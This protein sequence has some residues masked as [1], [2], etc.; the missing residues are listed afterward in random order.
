MEYKIGSSSLNLKVSS[1]EG[2]DLDIKPAFEKE[3]GGRGYSAYEIALQQ[4]FVGTEEE[5]LASLVGPQGAKGDKGD[6][7]DKGDKGDKGDRGITGDEGPRG[8]EGP[9]GP[10][11]DPGTSDHNLLTNR[12][13]ED[14][15]PMQ[16]ITGLIEALNN[17]VAEAGI[18][19]GD[20]EPTASNILIWI[21][22]SIP[23]ITGTQLIT[24]DNKGFYTADDEAF[25]LKEEIKSQLMTSDNKMFITAD[26]KEFILNESSSLLTMDNKEFIEANNKK[27]ILKEEY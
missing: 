8:P 2:P 23:P 26:D 11:G 21:D 27:F 10:K 3:V 19:I 16:S 25:I 17:I 18:Y 4:G 12:D 20:T 24:S 5:W 13:L 7:G 22:T 9:Q 1:S 14:Q 6:T 15:H